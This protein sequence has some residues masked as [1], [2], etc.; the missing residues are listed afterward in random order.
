MSLNMDIVLGPLITGTW[1]NSSLYTAELMQAAYYFIH[2]PNDSLRLKLFVG[3]VIMADTT[4]MIANYACVYLYTVTHWGDLPYLAT[5][6]LPV[7]IFI[8]ST[9]AVAG[10]AQSFLVLRYW[11]LSKNIYISLFLVLLILVAM[12]GILSAGIII[13]LHPTYQERSRIRIPAAAFLGSGALTDVCI[14]SSLL[15]E[16]RKMRSPFADTQSLLKRLS[17]RAIQTGSVG[18]TIA[19]AGLIA[20]LAN[21]ESNVP[22]GIVYC[23][24]RLYCL[25][26]L[27]NLNIRAAT[28]GRGKESGS[29][30][31]GV[32]RE[33]AH[34]D[35]EGHTHRSPVKVHIDKQSTTNS[36][37]VEIEMQVNKEYSYSSKTGG[38][39]P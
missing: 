30:G 5:Q 8:F 15:W 9:G 36:P 17:L 26:L 4:S 21:N 11:R 16:F 31:T 6:N 32:S 3:L 19:V 35:I 20:Y 23:L 1:V 22:L 24:G 33:R 2:F 28:G 27:A 34:T 18:A 12:A 39:L 29:S 7:P 13:S 38:L 14:A 10:F 37:H 25:S